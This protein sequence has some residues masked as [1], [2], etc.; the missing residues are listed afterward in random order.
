[1]K[2]L[3]IY[4]NP[5]DSYIKKNHSLVWSRRL[6]ENSI[7]V[8]SIYDLINNQSNNLKIELS[9]FFKI[10]FNKNKNFF[11]PSFNLKKDFSYLVLSNLVEKN[12][13][14]KNINLNTLKILAL[15]SYLKTN[16]FDKIII[17]TKNGDFLRKINNILGTRNN[18]NNKS[19]T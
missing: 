5:S 14:K 11:F 19:L 17:H 12:P 10:F 8:S 13:Y 18:L 3:D 16:K 1:M 7:K 6:N 2:I 9:D 15:N 4:E